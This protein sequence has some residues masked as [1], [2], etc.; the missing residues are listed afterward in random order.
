MRHMSNLKSFKVMLVVF[1][2]LLVALALAP[3]WTQ[4]RV[5]PAIAGPADDGEGDPL[6][7][8]DYSSGG[9][10]SSDNDIHDQTAVTDPADLGGR[11][12]RTVLRFGDV[13]FVPFFHGSTVSIQVIELPVRHTMAV[14]HA[15]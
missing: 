10:G 8:N 2:G 11:M 14:E 15:D 3:Q 1:V 6:D 4:A 7:S 12:I 5:N 13:M 9:G